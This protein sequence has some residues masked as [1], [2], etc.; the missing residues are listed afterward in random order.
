MNRY[1]KLLAAGRALTPEERRLCLARLALHEDFAALIAEVQW[2]WEEY[3]K[4][5]GKQSLAPHHGCLAHAGG[6]LCSLEE[7]QGVLRS[8]CAPKK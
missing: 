3:G 2:R 4:A 8:A 7:M 1:D 6:S 5:I